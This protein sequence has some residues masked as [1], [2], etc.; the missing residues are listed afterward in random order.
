MPASFSVR[1]RAGGEVLKPAHRAATRSVQ[2][3][4]QDLGVL[5]WM[6]DA[7]P[8]ICAG[9]DLLGIGDLWLDARWCE[10]AGGPGLAFQW[11]GGPNFV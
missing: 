2:H 9:D 6:R 4:C 5:P 8:F 1:A 11:L 10:A 3:L 7:I